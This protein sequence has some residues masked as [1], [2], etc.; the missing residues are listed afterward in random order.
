[1]QGTTEITLVNYVAGVD[2]RH[3]GALNEIVSYF[4]FGGIV[5]LALTVIAIYKLRRSDSNDVEY[6]TPGYPV[7]PAI[8]LG[9][10]PKQ[11]LLVEKEGRL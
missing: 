8:F 2:T 5:F 1:M 4:V 11:A 3:A 7:T 9:D 10:R 6:L